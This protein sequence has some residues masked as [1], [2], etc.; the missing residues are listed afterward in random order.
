M[1]ETSKE[2]RDTFEENVSSSSS[3]T[4][5]D[6][7][8]IVFDNDNGD[9]NEEVQNDKLTGRRIV[10]IKYLFSAISNTKHEH[11]DCTFSDLIFLKEQRKGFMSKY[12]FEC[13]MCKKIETV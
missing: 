10:D 4:T 6:D 8:D 2:T 7:L 12:V 1:N 3:T 11:T 5:L 13:K 9:N